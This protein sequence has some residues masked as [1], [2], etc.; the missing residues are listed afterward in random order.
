MKQTL[1]A[2]GLVAMLGACSSVYYNTMEKFGVHK[3][4]ILVDRVEEARDL[5]KEGQKQFQ[6]ALDQFRSIVQV[7]ESNLSKTYDRLRSEYEDS[8]ES[9]EAISAKINDIESVAAALFREWKGEL[10]QYSDS[11][12]RRDS[13]KKMKQTQAKYKSLIKSM[14]AAES[15]LQPVLATMHDQVLYLKHNLNASAIQSLRSEVIKIDQDVNALLAAMQKS[16]TEA[17]SFIEDMKE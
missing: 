10:K 16:I 9:A 1:L 3:R 13:E 15:R 8:K 12:L 11:S 5:Q 2:V 7:D 4:E 17:N 14:R 6:S